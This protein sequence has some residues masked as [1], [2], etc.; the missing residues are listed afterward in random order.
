MTLLGH[1]EMPLS[2]TKDFTFPDDWTKTSW[3]FDPTLG[4]VSYIGNIL[5]TTTIAGRDPKTT[6]SRRAMTSRF[7]PL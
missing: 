7:Q 5:E 6:Y 2:K 1:D 4:H 3:G